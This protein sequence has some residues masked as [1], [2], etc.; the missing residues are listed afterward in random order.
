[1]V[2][3]TQET[4]R[5]VS[6]GLPVAERPRTTPAA[7]WA[8]G[9]A[10]G[11][12]ALWLALSAVLS[13]T[14]AS[15]TGFRTHVWTLLLLMPTLCGIV[16][17]ALALAALRQLRRDRRLRGMT[18]AVLAI[19]MGAIVILPQVALTALSVR[20][21]VLGGIP[22]ID[23]A[24]ICQIAG[25]VVWLAIGYLLYRLHSAKD[26]AYPAATTQPL[27]TSTWVRWQGTDYGPFPPDLVQQ[28]CM[29]G[30]MPP[31]AFIRVAGTD[32]WKRPFDNSRLTQAVAETPA[33]QQGRG[34]RR[35]LVVWFSV[36]AALLVF[37]C[38]GLLAYQARNHTEQVQLTVGTAPCNAYLDVEPGAAV[39]VIDGSG[40]NVGRGKL[41]ASGPC[42]FFTYFTV[43]AEFDDVYR[44]RIG[45]HERPLT[46]EDL[47]RT[48]V[49]GQNGGRPMLSWVII[50]PG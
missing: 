44:I 38:G 19:I 43:P 7:A 26:P 21:L 36:V 17:I 47:D 20:D 31:D 34:R 33:D 37:V 12:I 45:E 41:S 13:N 27:T 39:E 30:E 11:G 5:V 16:A 25:P 46:Q 28:K 1:M 32:V 15:D 18:L 24:G 40:A 6:M 29:A 10:V 2:R 35:H 4:H 14:P 42:D 23:I 3:L 8:F 9:L 50:G 49:A 22:G 48:R